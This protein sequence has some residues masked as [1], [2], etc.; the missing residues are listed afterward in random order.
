ME[1]GVR[2]MS[3][4]TSKSLPRASR[5]AL[6]RPAGSA[7][8]KSMCQRSPRAK[9][10]VVA[11]KGWLRRI[12]HGGNQSWSESSPNRPQPHRNNAN[13]R[14]LSDKSPRSRPFATARYA[15]AGFRFR[16]RKVWGFKSLLVHSLRGLRPR[17]AEVNSA[18]PHP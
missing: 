6:I 11:L 1:H 2:S 12:A 14:E 8:T 18:G 10:L 16:Y 5:S 3:V 15:S 17:P 4:S 7:I 13:G 9:E